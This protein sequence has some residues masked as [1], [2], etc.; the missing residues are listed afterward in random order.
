[1]QVLKVRPLMR[2]HDYFQLRKTAHQLMTHSQPCR[3]CTDQN[4]DL[5][6]RIKPNDVSYSCNDAVPGASCW[7]YP[8]YLQLWHLVPIQP[9]PA[10]LLIKQSK[11]ASCSQVTGTVGTSGSWSLYDHNAVLVHAASFDVA[12]QTVEET[13]FAHTS[14]TTPII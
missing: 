4:D 12:V 8:L 7:D 13:L 3:S 11:D 10:D 14:S 5:N 9:H 6:G 1:M 2:C